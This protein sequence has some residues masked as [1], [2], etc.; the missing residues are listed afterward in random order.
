MKVRKVK[1]WARRP[2]PLE[3]KRGEGWFGEINECYT[4]LDGQYAV[5]IRPVD[6]EWGSVEHAAIRNLA[7]TDIPWSEKQ[8]IKNEL[9][10]KERVAIEVFPAESNLVDEANMYHLWVLPK[11]FEMPFT[12]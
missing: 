5:M 4:S 3:L 8:R 6:T 9:F 12:I 2:S 1:G 11:G 7:S 10:A